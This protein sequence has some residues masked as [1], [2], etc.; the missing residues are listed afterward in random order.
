MPLDMIGLGGGTSGIVE[1]IRRLLRNAERLYII[2]QRGFVAVAAQMFLRAIYQGVVLRTLLRLNAEC[3]CDNHQCRYEN[4]PAHANFPI[5]TRANLTIIFRISN[6]APDF[7]AVFWTLTMNFAI[8]AA[9]QA[10]LR[11][12]SGGIDRVSGETRFFIGGR[13][14]LRRP[15]RFCRRPASV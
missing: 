14:V 13:D 4:L 11:L 3:R 1:M 2:P 6:F 9:F 7:R 8:F 15:L 12:P 10:I 5:H